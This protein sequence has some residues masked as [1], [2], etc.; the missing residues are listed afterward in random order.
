VE[1]DLNTEVQNLNRT[2][3]DLTLDDILA[4]HTAS[5][6]FLDYCQNV[7]HNAEPFEF[8]SGIVNGSSR[9]TLYTTYVAPTGAKVLNFTEGGGTGIKQRLDADHNDAAAWE[10]ARDLF[11]VEI[12]RNELPRFKKRKQVVLR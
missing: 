2:I 1:Q 4:D 9:N 10:D 7:E 12:G 3:D 5:A 8:V 6:V 11:K